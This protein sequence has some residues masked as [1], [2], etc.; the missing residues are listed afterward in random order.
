M[1]RTYF[2]FNGTRLSYLRRKGRYPVVFIHGFTA[3]AEIWTPLVSELDP[4]L[5]II[6]VDLLG[7]GHSGM[8]DLDCSGMDVS[9]VIH[10]Q[11]SAIA[12]LIGSLGLKDFALV[13]SS[14]GGWVSMELAVN[15]AKPARLALI[16]T[17]GVAPLSDIAFRTG[18]TQLVELYKMQ[19]N[20]M[21]PI[22]DRVLDSKDVNATMM[23]D[24][25]LQS[26]D[27]NVSVIWATE[28]PILNIVHGRE[29]ADKLRFSQFHAVDGAGHTPFTTNPGQV[30][31]ILNRFIRRSRT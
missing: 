19:D 10:L 23:A 24:S 21:S 18:F 9:K 17:A 14:L 31:E 30:G 13:G 3:S 1:D 12:D 22:L 27:L 11:A 8:P 20:A 6:M 4:D 28:D 29:F 2:D 25:L 7:H 16:D 26:M 5:D 15:F